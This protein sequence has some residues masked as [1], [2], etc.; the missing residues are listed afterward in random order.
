M[1]E[2][3]SRGEPHSPTLFI[4]AS[5]LHAHTRKQLYTQGHRV[6]PTPL[7]LGFISNKN[8]VHKSSKLRY[9][10]QQKC[11]KRFIYRQSNIF[12]CFFLHND[13][14][15]QELQQRAPNQKRFTDREVGR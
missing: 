14:R 4:P 5:P 3:D 10:S 13:I 11:N 9:V 2:H 6:I 7:G 1:P 8:T 15:L 12:Y